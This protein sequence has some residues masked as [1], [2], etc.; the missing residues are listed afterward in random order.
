MLSKHNYEMTQVYTESKYDSLSQ[1]TGLAG[2]TS[3]KY[4]ASLPMQE[5]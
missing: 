4:R 5:T 1:D 2:G 3:G